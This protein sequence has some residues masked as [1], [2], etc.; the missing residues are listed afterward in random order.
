MVERRADQKKKRI[1]ANSY[2]NRAIAN[3]PSHSELKTKSNEYGEEII[4]AKRSHWSNYLEDMTANEIWTANKYIREPVGDGGNPR[5]PT[6]KTKNAAGIV[7]SINSNDAKSKTFAKMFFPPP[8]PV[9]D[10]FTGYDY[11]DPLPDPPNITAEQVKRHVLKTSPYKAHGPDE[12][13]NVVLQ[14]C[15][16]LILSR[17]TNIYQV[18]RFHSSIF[19]ISFIF[20]IICLVIFSFLSLLFLL[21]FMFRNLDYS[22]YLL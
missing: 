22:C 17:L 5:I 12:I 14:Q 1:R 13:P 18:L 10:N 2:R 8:P 4:K 19:A 16:S 21:S 9:I 7:T 20:V 6:L 15:V 11:P 3:H